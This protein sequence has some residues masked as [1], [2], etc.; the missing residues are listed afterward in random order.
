MIPFT[1]VV[2]LYIYIYSWLEWR[3]NVLLHWSDKQK[4]CW[5]YPWRL[6]DSA[7]NQLR[8]CTEDEKW[9]LNITLEIRI[10]VSLYFFDVS[11]GS[12]INNILIAEFH[13][14]EIY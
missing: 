3:G 9:K 14:K 1:C 8:Q 13:N 12:T 5:F 10:F 6:S 4:Y 2:Y 11:M 7:T